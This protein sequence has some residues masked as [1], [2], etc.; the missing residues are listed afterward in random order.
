MSMSESGSA[1]ASS[2]KAPSGKHSLSRRAERLPERGGVGKTAIIGM[3]EG[4]G[5]A[6]AMPIENM[7]KTTLRTTMH[8]NVRKGSALFADENPSR[9][10]AVKRHCAVHHSAKAHVAGMAHAKCM[11]SGLPARG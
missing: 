10:G 9:A 2:S 5:G 7:T 11:A 1:C 3:R 8:K 6:K 4:K